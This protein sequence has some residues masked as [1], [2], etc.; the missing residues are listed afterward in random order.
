MATISEALEIAIQHQNGGRL[1]IAEQIYRQILAVEPNHTDAVYALGLI[2]FQGGK[3]DDAVACWRRT[4]ELKP[5]FA[6]A[7]NNL[8][9][10]FKR[11]G[12]LDEAV[13]C[14]RRALELKPDYAEARSNLGYAQTESAAVPP[15][16]QFPRTVCAC[17]TC[18]SPCHYLPGMLAPGDIERIAAHLSKSAAAVES[19]LRASPGA[20]VSGSENDR[21]PALR[22]PCIVPKSMEGGMRCVF[23]DSE[24]RCIVHPV[25]P[26]GCSHF[27]SHMDDAESERRGRALLR[28][29]AVDQDYQATWQRLVDA[30]Q[31]TESPAAR[32]AKM[33]EG[34]SLH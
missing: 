33:N 11:Q 8:G 34:K 17:E 7:H 24:G 23:L 12:K 2:A 15:R 10:A 20:L 31:T 21:M 26:F 1:Q 13:A 14:Y 22:I 25:A 30:G 9:V 6:Q 19:L 18:R 32:R 27:D 5:D 3:L 28:A 29:A 16:D 4:V